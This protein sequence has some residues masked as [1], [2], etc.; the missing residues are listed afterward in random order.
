MYFSEQSVTKTCREHRKAVKSIVMAFAAFLGLSLSSTAS[1][2]IIQYSIEG[3]FD[4][5]NLAG[6]GYS[7]VFTFDDSSKPNVLGSVPWTTELLSYSLDVESLSKHWTLV[8]W[9]MEH[10][11]SQWIDTNAFL[12]SLAYLATPGPEGNP[13]AVSEFLDD[14]APNSRSKHVKWYDWSVWNTIQ[15]VSTDFDPIVTVTAVPAPSSV[16]LLL[17][18]MIGMIV[19]QLRHRKPHSMGLASILKRGRDR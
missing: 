17:T 7:E 8:D 9:P 14:G 18:G 6:L 5:G 1:A 4:A 2:G 10:T 16:L 3:T 15:T 11:F 19:I 12:N 13:P